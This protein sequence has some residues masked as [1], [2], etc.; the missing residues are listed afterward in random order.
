MIGVRLLRPLPDSW[1]IGI[2]VALRDLPGRVGL[3]IRWVLIK[4]L[5]AECGANVAVYTGVHLHDLDRARFGS[6]I[7]IGEMCFIG[8]SGGLT[9]GG[10]VSIAHASTVLTEEHDYRVPGSLRET[11]LIFSPVTIEPDVWIGAGVRIL[12]GVTIGAGAAV[13]A[14]SVVTRDVPPAT[15]AVGVP[16]RVLK[17]RVA[18]A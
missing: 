4:R 8:A 10:N 5:A 15:I 18:E 9:I 2:L 17:P 1:C 12:S 3:G 6:N 11:P 16:A 13:G 7:K 14:G